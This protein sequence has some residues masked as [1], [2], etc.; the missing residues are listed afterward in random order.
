MTKLL[1]RVSLDKLMD[2]KIDFA[3]K[4]LFGNEKNKEIT[5]VF[6]N[7]ILQKAG[8]DPIQSISFLN[9]EFSGEYKHDKSSR[10]DILAIT[11]KKEQVN[12]EIQFSNE[13]DMV[14]RT[15]YYWS[16]IYAA[17]M[18]KGMSYRQLQ[19]VISINILNF[20]LLK[21][22]KFHTI[23]HLKEQEELF[24]L[25]DVMELHFIEMSKLIQDWKENKLDPWS[26]VLARWLLMLGIV[27]QR[28]QTV[29]E[30]IY[31][32]LEEIAMKDETLK[33]AFNRW[34]ELSATQEERLE[35]EARL[36]DLLD[37]ESVVI[38]AELR[39]QEVRAE[40]EA[41]NQE[42]RAEMEARNQEMQAEMQARNQEMQ[43]EMQARNQKALA[44]A[45][46]RNQEALAKAKA[47]AEATKQKAVQQMNEQFALKLLERGTN[48]ETTSEL[49]G[50]PLQA[51]EA[52]NRKRS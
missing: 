36:K 4:A 43:A 2:L 6:L 23:F 10:L 1:K 12:I 11:D 47:E 17:P 49:T 27:D 24:P 39:K 16:R 14:K 7:A 20:P 13:Y 50:L 21:T 31:L 35:Y 37:K 46:A 51:I 29:Y 9:I 52:L 41:R 22:K 40:M 3:F 5:V 38:E 25:T 48:I 34:D 42:L 44:E 33:S 26:D 18:K 8:R 19:P 30:K 15:I 32:E 28:D 45:E